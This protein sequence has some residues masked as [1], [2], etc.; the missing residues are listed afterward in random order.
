MY[1][2]FLTETPY[3]CSINIFFIANKIKSIAYQPP[4][5]QP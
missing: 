5:T 4:R 2:V 1:N 3:Y